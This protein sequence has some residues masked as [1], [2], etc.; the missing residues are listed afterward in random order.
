LGTAGFGDGERA[1]C[2]YAAMEHLANGLDGVWPLTLALDQQEIAERINWRRMCL[3]S[4]GGLIVLPV[5]HKAILPVGSV[6]P[7]GCLSRSVWAALCARES[8]LSRRARTRLLRDTPVALRSKGCGGQ[9]VGERI[10][11]KRIVEPK[12]QG[13]DRP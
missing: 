6:R 11:A 4:R 3:R 10:W 7:D 9:K 5:A 12:G 8:V 2:N 13:L 1:R